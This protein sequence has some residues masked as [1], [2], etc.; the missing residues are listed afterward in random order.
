MIIETFLLSDAATDSQGKLNVLGAFDTILVKSLPATHPAC[1]VAIRI[2]FKPTEYGLHNIEIAL[3]DS[4]SKGIIAPATIKLDV[5]STDSL[6]PSASVNVI[7]NINGLKIESSGTHT[8]SL[9]VD[10]KEIASIPLFVK[11]MA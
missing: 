10:K 2:R 8:I 9:V 1:A 11:I 5:K 4:K 3:K 6:M 7:M